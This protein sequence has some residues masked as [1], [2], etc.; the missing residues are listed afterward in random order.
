MTDRIKGCYVTFDEDIRD[1]DVEELINA[2][3]MLKRVI[4][5][6]TDVSSPT[7]HVARVRARQ[8]LVGRILAVLEDEGDS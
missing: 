2:I 6:S 3:S 1:D 8:A 7:D 5:V 4:D